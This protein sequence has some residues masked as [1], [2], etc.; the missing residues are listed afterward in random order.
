MVRRRDGSLVHPRF[1]RTTLEEVC[2][3]ALRS[4]HT[5]QRGPGAFTI[6]I[7]NL[8]D[9]SARMRREIEREISRYLGEPA[10]VRVER[11]SQAER[12]PGGK[13]RTFTYA[14]VAGSESSADLRV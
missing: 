14:P 7:E 3:E 8:E 1:I 9:P 2:G 11:V 4:F 6:E 12:N 10:S 5:F 13:L